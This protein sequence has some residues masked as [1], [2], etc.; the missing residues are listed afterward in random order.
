MVNVW[1]LMAHHVECCR[2]PMIQ[3]ATANNR[4]AIGWGDVGNLTQYATREEIQAAVQGAFLGQ[5]PPGNVRSAGI[6]LWNFRGGA[7][8]FY[9][10][11]DDDPDQ[12]RY[13]MQ[14]GDLVILK[15]NTG[16]RRGWQNSKVMRVHP[17][18]GR[19]DYAP[20]PHLVNCP[21]L[22]QHQRRVQ[23]VPHI[24]PQ[25]LWLE[26]GRAAPHQNVR[27]NALVRCQFPV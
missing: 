14:C 18:E 21:G 23:V 25:A 6:Q 15:T 11:P 7:H 16:P 20:P 22:Y 13:A 1:R 19:Y 9:P 26:A 3:W 2:L 27:R 10:N 12:N 4:I 8:W 24:D 17:D 5:G